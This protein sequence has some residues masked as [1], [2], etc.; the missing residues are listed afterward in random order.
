[1]ADDEQNPW[2]ILGKTPHYDDSWVTLVAHD[3]EN[4][5]GKRSTYATVHFKKRGLAVLPVDREGHTYFVGQ[6]RFGARRYGWEVPAGGA[7]A[8]EAA[9]ETARR[10][11]AEEMGFAAAQWHEVL[12]VY[13]S[14]S[15]T[16]EH[17][18]GFVAWDLAPRQPKP[19]EQ[20]VLAVR[21]MPFAE[22]VHMACRG[23]IADVLSVAVI[24]R[25]RLM[26]ERGEL[27]EALAARLL[28]T[29]GP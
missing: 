5:A 12:R 19:D 26:A 25:V 24:L 13:I 27:P 8:G 21:R 17:A 10:E 4:A 29:E 23:E 11:L 3:V 6:Y 18:V 1:M 20:E 28:R 15:L 16:D 9:L 2:R 22:A 14:G 7:D